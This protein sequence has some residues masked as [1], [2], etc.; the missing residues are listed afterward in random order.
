MPPRACN[1]SNETSCWQGA[2][3][4][5]ITAASFKNEDYLS[6]KHTV[7]LMLVCWIDMVRYT[8]EV[9]KH[10]KGYK[11]EQHSTWVHFILLHYVHKFA[12]Y[13]LRKIYTSFHGPRW[14]WDHSEPQQTGLSSAEPLYSLANWCLITYKLLQ[15]N[16]REPVTIASSSVSLYTPRSKKTNLEK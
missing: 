12:C 5:I 16:F 3:S 6:R 10:R 4:H 15:Q 11:L 8:A 1:P 14:Q 7:T 2:S 9:S 13:S